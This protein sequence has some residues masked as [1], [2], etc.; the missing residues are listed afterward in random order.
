MR[1]AARLAFTLGLAF[2]FVVFGI[3]KFINPHGWQGYVPLWIPFAVIPFLYAVGILE[4]LLGLLLLWPTTSRLA[5]IVC[6]AFLLGTILTLGWNETM[7]R[8]AGLFALAVGLA[9][10]P[11]ELSDYRLLRKKKVMG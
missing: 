7:I 4:I 10:E 5:A 3:D 6:A 2:V 11:L 1:F 9:L 8:D